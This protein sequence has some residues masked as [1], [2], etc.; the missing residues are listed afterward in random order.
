[1]EVKPEPGK[2]MAIIIA[3]EEYRNKAAI[4]SV[5]FAKNDA[6]AFKNMLIE[7]L[8]YEE[9]DII[10]WVGTD[11]VQNTLHNDLP[12]YISQLSPDHEFIFYYAGH[13]FYGPEGNKL[14]CWDSHQNNL[15]G[16]TVSLKQV[17]FDPLQKSGCN[18]SLIFLDCCSSYL[19]DHLNTRD[20][21]GAMSTQ[22]LEAFINTTQ[23]NAIFMSCSPGEKSSSN[24]RLRHGIW[25]FHLI[26]AL[27]GNVQECIIR[28]Q[29]I[30]SN[31]LQNYL[32]VAVPKFINEEKSRYTKQTPY[33]KISSANEFLI[34]K[35]PPAVQ[36]IDISKPS[37]NLDFGAAYLRK[38]SVTPV[39]TARGFK[40][41]YTAPRFI[42]RVTQRF[43]QD[44]FYEEM[45]ELM[46][47]VYEQTKKVFKLKSAD[48]KY[49]YE[50]E[51][52]SLSCSYF[53]YYLSVEQHST[54]S[55][56]AVI[57]HAIYP[58]V[59]LHTLPDAF[60]NIFPVGIDELI[61]PIEGKISFEDLVAKFENLEEQ[62]G[63]KLVENGME[64]TIEYITANHTSMVVNIGTQ[65]LVITN[66][67]RKKPIELLKYALNDIQ[68]L[69]QQ[70]IKLLN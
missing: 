54:D 5:L 29:Y 53:N 23:Y 26:E 16:T 47:T 18:R 66:Y 37:L 38:N 17:L 63:G 43:V 48:I 64:Q 19:S 59:P 56:E 60:D 40:K 51:G 49:E 58:L 11:A 33:A 24:G 61:I 35:I 57:R 36:E 20:V 10:Y 67:L 41:G 44:M 39:K 42:S 9:G 22:E 70:Q 32:S 50:K 7:H 1:M 31:S 8:G 28:D 6:L 15:P 68:H 13:G 4:P 27:S 52:G 65:E 69:S 45:K 34:R 14:T 2:R 46:Q 62:E 3:I 21:I 30:T 25:T 55:A 12:Y